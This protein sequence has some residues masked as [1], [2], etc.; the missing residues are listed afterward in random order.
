MGA[1]DALTRKKGVIVGDDVMK[2]SLSLKDKNELTYTLVAVP[3]RPRAQVRYS[4]H[5]KN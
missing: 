4:R 5:R 2:V 3:I 1:T